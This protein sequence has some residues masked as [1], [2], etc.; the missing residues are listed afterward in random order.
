M[1]A[2]RA[3]LLEPEARLL[4]LTGPGGIGKT[5]LALAVGE[6]PLDDFTDG[7]WFVDVSALTDS[8]LVLP[9]RTEKSLRWTTVCAASEMRRIGSVTARWSQVERASAAASATPI[10]IAR[11]ST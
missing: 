6:S 7:V 9:A 1:H 4:T 8:S 3:L 5:R 2:A 11:M 10:T